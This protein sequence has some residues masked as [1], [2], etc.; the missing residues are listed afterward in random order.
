MCAACCQSVLEAFSTLC[1]P[2]RVSSLNV[3]TMLGFSVEAEWV[4]DKD[5]KPLNI[6]DHRS[7]FCEA[8]D[9][10]LPEGAKRL[11]LVTAGF[12]DCLLGGQLTGMTSLNVRLLEAMGY[13][14]LVIK[15][16]DWPSAEK[17]VVRVKYLDD[18]MKRVAV[19][20]KNDES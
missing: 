9:K 3:N 5:G 4:L 7:S 1:P 18:I 2:T 14:V 19:K 13:T 8:G 15:Y 11:A 16:S 17:L 10:T 12:Q 20:S 6:S